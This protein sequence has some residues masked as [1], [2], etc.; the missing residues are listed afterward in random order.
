M[1]RAG[2]PT[3]PAFVVFPAETYGSVHWRLGLCQVPRMCCVRGR[4]VY[5]CPSGSIFGVCGGAG[6]FWWWLKSPLNRGVRLDG[7][8]V[9]LGGEHDARRNRIGMEAGGRGRTLPLV[10]PAPP[11]T[12]AATP[13]GRGRAAGD[14]G[15]CGGLPIPTPHPRGRQRG[16]LAHA[17]TTPLP[18]AASRPPAGPNQKTYLL[19]T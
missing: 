16:P 7:R 4:S 19:R 1:T 18:Y 17:D 3:E 8:I 11:Q 2:S 15:T 12:P 5:C 9:V 10:A 6:C 13:P 14:P